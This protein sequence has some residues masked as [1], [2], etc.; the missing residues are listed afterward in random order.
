MKRLLPAVLLLCAAVFIALKIF[1]R[2]TMKE[3]TVVTIPRGAIVSIN[4]VSVGMSPLTRFVPGDGVH[5]T[6][7][8][9]GFFPRDTL[10]GA[11]PDTVFLQLCQGALLIVNTSPTA[12]SVL[13]GNFSGTSPCSIVVRPGNPV[14]ITVC[15]SMGLT[16]T[17]TVNVLSSE[18]KLLNIA[19]PYLFT[20]SFSGLDLAVIPEEL[21]PF[22][23]GPVT[24]GRN[25][26]TVSQ[27]T[28]F[29]NS[30]DPLLLRG[31]TG[32]HG[33]T[34]LLDSIMR[35]SWRGP[36][37]F[38]HDTTAYTPC[39][40]MEDHPVT[41]VNR[42]GALWYCEWLSENSSSGLSF[43]LPDSGDWACLAAPGKDLPPNLSDVS[44]PILT[45]YPD[46]NDGWRETS[47][48][49]AMG[50][51]EWGL[52]S[53]QGNVWEWTSEPCTAVGGSWLSSLSDCTA[54]AVIN[55]DEDLGYPFVGFRVV[56]YDVPV[57]SFTADPNNTEEGL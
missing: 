25:E 26:V 39:P 40:G 16:V 18:T 10:V 38:N 8:K 24:V 37:C 43:R 47:P 57:G 49:G 19:V 12:C 9:E 22:A 21:L 28:R 20:D 15:G 32:V 44:E 11:T 36:V 13:A 23:M 53:M 46:V 7:E 56:A 6:V 29:M 30:V 3:L 51:S 52:G 48:S 33:R 1:P 55:L 45:R 31:D 41:G 50:Y 34:I 27:F 35:S 5:L 14:D 54:D 4:G 42:Q 2:I 17:R